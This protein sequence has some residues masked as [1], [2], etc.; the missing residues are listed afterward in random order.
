MGIRKKG[1]TLLETLVAALVLILFGTGLLGLHVAQ[2][3]FLLHAQHRVQALDYARGVADI[4]LELGREAEIIDE[5]PPE[6]KAQMWANWRVRFEVLTRNEPE[7]LTLGTHTAPADT[8]PT[9][10][11]TD[12]CVLPDSYFKQTLKGKLSY[13]VD[14]FSVGTI[15]ARRV[16][17]I[18]EW[19]EN[20]PR[21]QV[22]E[23]SLFI[24]AYY[25][26][27]NERP[28]WAYDCMSWWFYSNISW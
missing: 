24:V 2:K 19:E 26:D 1:F 5:T 13:V 17:I 27:A 23:E 14:T 10:I 25:D 21:T 28:L 3:A 11:S 7:D 20:L 6:I 16:E 22:K 8:T 4:L 12:I 15:N 9:T 18:V